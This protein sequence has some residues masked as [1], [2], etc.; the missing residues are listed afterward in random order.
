M[1]ALEICIKTL[2]QARERRDVFLRLER[3]LSA[4]NSLR[5]VVGA[6]PVTNKFHVCMRL[7][8]DEPEGTRRTMR[9]FSDILEDLSGVELMPE[10]DAKNVCA[11]L[12]D[13]MACEPV[14]PSNLCR[15]VAEEMA[16][17]V[18]ALEAA[19]DR[20]ENQW[21]EMA[22][23][24]GLPT[25]PVDF[26]A[27]GCPAGSRLCDAYDEKLALFIVRMMAMR[28]SDKWKL[29]STAEVAD[30]A[31]ACFRDGSCDQ[32]TSV[33]AS[34]VERVERVL[35]VLKSPREAR[36]FSLHW[37]RMKNAPVATPVA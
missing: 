19:I 24:L 35:G 2:R 34:S 11:G 12:E 37:S 26:V 29:P 31:N 32:L 21:P 1:N 3:E 25:R 8:A 4:D 15:M 16:V 17:D 10:Q 36:D 22:L 13:D 14:E 23:Q 18:E 6:E 7:A 20:I 28:G 9:P 27:L 33:A 5:A 30:V